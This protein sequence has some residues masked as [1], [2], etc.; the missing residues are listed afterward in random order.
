MTAKESAKAERLSTGS[1]RPSI[2]GEVRDERWGP[3]RA[4]AQ[5]VDAG[6]QV[7]DLEGSIS[8]CSQ[9]SGK[10]VDGG[11]LHVGT[12]TMQRNGKAGLAAIGRLAGRQALGELE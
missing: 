8:M 4:G 5:Q 9:S 10:V 12:G 1:R 3:G 11:N 6:I 7:G 2:E